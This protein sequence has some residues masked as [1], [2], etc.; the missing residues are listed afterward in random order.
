MDQPILDAVTDERQQPR[1]LAKVAL[2]FLDRCD[3]KG[4]EARRMR[5]VQEWLWMIANQAAVEGPADE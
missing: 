2:I 3:L 5:E 1:T 4:V